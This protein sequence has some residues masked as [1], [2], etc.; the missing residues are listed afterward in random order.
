MSRIVYRLAVDVSLN[1]RIGEA[2]KIYKI[3]KKNLA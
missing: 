1:V 3:M 2:K